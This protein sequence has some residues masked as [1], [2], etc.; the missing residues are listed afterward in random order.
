MTYNGWTLQPL[1]DVILIRVVHPGI[2]SPG[3]LPLSGPSNGVAS[4]STR[5][6]ASSNSYS[7]KHRGKGSNVLGC[8]ET[9]P[10]LQEL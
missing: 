5:S 4:K 7:D 10:E 1:I 9:G 2:V 8:D 3:G 6:T